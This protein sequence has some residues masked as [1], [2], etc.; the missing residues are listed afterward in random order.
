MGAI[1]RF[2]AAAL[3][4]RFFVL[5]CLAALVATGV[6]AYRDLPSRPSPT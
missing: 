4:Q 3:R 5:L 6:M 1:E 2:V